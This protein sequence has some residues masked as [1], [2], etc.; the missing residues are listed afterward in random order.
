M[1]PGIR[2]PWHNYGFSNQSKDWMN[3]YWNVITRK[4]IWLL[5]T[6]TIIDTRLRF[7]TFFWLTQSPAS[8]AHVFVL[9]INECEMHGILF[10]LQFLAINSSHTLTKQKIAMR[11]VYELLDNSFNGAYRLHFNNHVEKKMKEKKYCKTNTYQKHQ[12]RRAYSFHI[13]PDPC[14]LCSVILILLTSFI[15]EFCSLN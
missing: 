11:F 9:C 10:F 2:C 12:K 7:L 13:Y 1:N 5:S 14:V 8:F 6:Y 4:I 3:Y 15:G